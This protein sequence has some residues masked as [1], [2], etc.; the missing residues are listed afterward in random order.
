MVP[1]GEPMRI[2]RQVRRADGAYGVSL[3]AHPLKR[4]FLTL[5]SWRDDDAVFLAGA[6]ELTLAYSGTVADGETGYEPITVAENI[7]MKVAGLRTGEA[8]TMVLREAA[9]VAAAQ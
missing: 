9:R 1:G 4:E 2:H 6:P 5:S 3:E 7:A 8:P